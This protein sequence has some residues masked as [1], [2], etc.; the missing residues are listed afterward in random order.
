[1][2]AAGRLNPY[3]HRVFPFAEAGDALA[4]VESGHA[5]GKVVIDTTGGVTDGRRGSASDRDRP[6]T[7]DEPLPSPAGHGSARRDRSLLETTGWTLARALHPGALPGPVDRGQHLEHVEG[8]R[9]VRAVRAALDRVG[10]IP[11]AQTAARLLLGADGAE[12]LH[13]RR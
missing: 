7:V 3:V 1:L 13:H 2:V 9:R 10:Q 6:G 5:S 4:L 12:Q 11:D 8:E